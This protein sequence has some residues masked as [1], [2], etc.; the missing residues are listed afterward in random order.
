MYFFLLLLLILLLLLES[1]YIT[2]LVR[3]M[4][5]RRVGKINAN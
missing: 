1:E 4:N 5:V 3:S 2:F